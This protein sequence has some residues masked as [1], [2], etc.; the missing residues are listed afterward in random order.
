MR[1]FRFALTLLLAGG[2]LGAQPEPRIVRQPAKDVGVASLEA[3]RVL[4]QATLPQF[5]VFAGF[6]FTDQ[7]LASGIDFVHRSTEDSL[8]NW[9]PVHYDHGNGVSVADVDGDGDLDIY[10]LTQ[11]GSNRLYRNVGGGKFEDMTDAAG[12][13]LED[14]ISVAASFGDIDNDGD[15]DLYVTS[16]RGG[17]TLFVNDGKGNFLDV[18]GA[19]GV[20]Y[21]GHSSG[22]VFFDYDGDGLLDLF[23]TNVGVY[24]TDEQ[25]PGGYYRGM[26]AAFEGHRFPE[27]TEKSRLY[28]N[29]GNGR[30]ADVSAGAACSDDSW[31]GDATFTDLNG[32]RRPDLYVLNMQGDDHY[33]ENR[34]SDGWVDRTPELFPKTSWGAMGVKFFDWDN[35]GRFDLMVTDMHSD[36]HDFDV[37]PLHDE[38]I[39]FD[40]PL[41]DG[42]NNL[43]GN[44]F[45]HQQADGTFREISDT[46]GAENF[47][48]WGLSVGDLNA[49]GFEDAFVASSMNFPFRYGVDSVL[50]NDRGAMLRDSEFI[51]GVEPRRDGRTSKVL[52]DMDC[53]GPDKANKLCEKLSGKFSIEGSLGTRASVVFDIDDDGDLDI[54]T[55][56]FNDQPQVL[57]SDLAAKREILWVKITLH[58]TASNRDGLGALVRVVTDRGTLTRYHDGKS[59]YLAQSSAPLYVG[60]GDATRIERIEVAWPSGADQTVTAGLGLNSLV[61]I[62]EPAAP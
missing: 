49:D 56:E 57:V 11:L 36:M 4:Q 22:S 31:S 40:V 43:A 9:I 20:G 21:V 44:A 14:R 41:D 48:P 28:R 7:V 52:F 26:D 46:N 35:D 18:T 38:K 50:L 58:G 33:Y 2:A 37:R 29:L 23:V 61:E 25:G 54:V 39:K 3:R 55:G 45:Y 15:P 8:Q 12:V 16:V 53:D 17:N 24:T 13:G 6:S 62:T 32:D 51:L 19:S 60:L 5:G 34:G 47:W 59:G 10:F 27:R 30:F 1:N 42:E